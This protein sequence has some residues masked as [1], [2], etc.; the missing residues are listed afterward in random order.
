MTNEREVMGLSDEDLD[1]LES[2][3]KSEILS[4]DEVKNSVQSSDRDIAN[5]HTPEDQI[6]LGDLGTFK[7]AKE[8]DIV[9]VFD[10]LS[11]MVFQLKSCLFRVS[12][13]NPGRT[14]F[15]AELLNGKSKDIIEV[16]S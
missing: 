14:R 11:G 12:Y 1:A 10:K 6:N 7:R 13:I 15:S 4:P 16:S 2:E 3:V 8:E 9:D 5:D